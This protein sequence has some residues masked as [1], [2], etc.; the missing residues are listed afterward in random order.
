MFTDDWLTSSDQTIRRLGKKQTLQARSF[1]AV[2]AAV[3]V[4]Q[5]SQATEAKLPAFVVSEQGCT[6]IQALSN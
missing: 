5:F 4:L 3:E 2:R 1:P 6:L